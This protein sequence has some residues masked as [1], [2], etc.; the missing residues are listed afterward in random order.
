MNQPQSDDLYMNQPP[1]SDDLYINN[2]NPR[3]TDLP[4]STR[5]EDPRGTSPTLYANKPAPRTTDPPETALYANQG[6]DDIYDNNDILDDL[7]PVRMRNREFRRVGF[8]GRI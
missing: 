1:T 5:T 2:P 3:T 6:E 7:P 4:I 8:S